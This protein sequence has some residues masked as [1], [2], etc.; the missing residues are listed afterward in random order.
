MKEAFIKLSFVTHEQL[1]YFWNWNRHQIWELH[2]VRLFIETLNHRNEIYKSLFASKLN[3]ALG[4]LI[5]SLIP[6][7]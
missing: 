6:V 1:A 7:L 5:N 2:Q 3:Q 4:K